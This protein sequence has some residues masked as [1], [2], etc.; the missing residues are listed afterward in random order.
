MERDRPE[1]L[2]RLRELIWEELEHAVG[3]RSHGWR[4]PTLATRDGDGVDARTVVLRDA[5]PA[6]KSLVFYTDG[7]SPKVAQLA[8]QPIA[9][10]VCWCPKLSWQLRLRCRVEVSTEGLAVSSRWAKLQ[11]SKSAQDYLSPLSPGTRLNH[12][13]RPAYGERSHFALVIAEVSVMDWLELH[14]DGHR[15]A[16]FDKSGGHW[17]VP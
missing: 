10:L 12:P 3:E 2:T 4:T 11:F 1:D 13:A 8:A 9:T 7:R 16:V 5:N 17:A 15:R 14:P 6:A